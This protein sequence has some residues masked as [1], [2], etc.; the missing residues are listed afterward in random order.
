VIV[1][2]AI[3]HMM[4]VPVVQ[5][6]GMAVM[7]DG[8]VAAFGAMCVGMTLVRDTGCRHNLSS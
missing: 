8:G 3:V 5:I 1:D 2:V 7:L 4:Q 6:V